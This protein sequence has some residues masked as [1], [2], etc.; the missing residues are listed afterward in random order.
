MKKSVIS[1]GLALVAFANATKARPKEITD[2][3]IMIGLLN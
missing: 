2:F 3:F 1:L